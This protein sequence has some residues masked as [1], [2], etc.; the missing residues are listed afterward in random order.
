M[1]QWMPGEILYDNAVNNAQ[2]AQRSSEIAGILWHQGENDSINE[3][4]AATYQKR[5]IQMITQLRKDLGNNELPVIVGELGRFAST[6]QY[7]K[8]KYVAI[9]N[10]SLRTMPSVVENCG[11]VNA[12]SESQESLFS[13]RTAPT[14][15]S[16]WYM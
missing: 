2:L 3:A 15:F 1:S 10:E 7:G 13:P 8:L 14:K 16:R 12:C 5:F 4:D 11:F 9:V 6:Y